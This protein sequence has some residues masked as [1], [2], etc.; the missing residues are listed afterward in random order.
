MYRLPV[1]WCAYLLGQD[2]RFHNRAALVPQHIRIES[3]LSFGKG[4]TGTPQKSHAA[5]Y[6]PTPPSSQSPECH[7]RT[8]IAPIV[9]VERRRGAVDQGRKPGSGRPQPEE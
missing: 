3:N 7:P 2:P 1:C 5:T 4:R 6:T 9:S 8:Q